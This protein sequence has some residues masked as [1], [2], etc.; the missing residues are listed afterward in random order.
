HGNAAFLALRLVDLLGPR[1]GPA[2]ADVFRYQ[3]AATERV[4]RELP[5]DCT[6]TSHLT[7]LV[8][9]VAD[10][11]QDQDVR[12]VVPALLAYAHYLENEVRLEDA[13]DVLET[14]LCVADERLGQS[15][16]VA[17]HLRVGRVN[18]K[19]NRFAEADAAYSVAGELAATVADIHGAFLSRVGRAIAVQAR[20]NLSAAEQSFREIAAEAQAVEERE[21]QAH[22]EHAL[23]T[24]LLFRGQMAD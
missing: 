20:G 17:A 15:D 23:G 13:L 7:G 2:H 18:R 10:A 12:I 6:E 14:L 21:I 11:F 9:A 8:R 1:R 16:A 4:C 3:H 22:A 24:T 19:L 5:N